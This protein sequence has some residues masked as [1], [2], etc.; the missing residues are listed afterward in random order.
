MHAHFKRARPAYHAFVSGI[1]RALRSPMRD[2]CWPLRWQPHQNGR[3]ARVRNVAENFK[4]RVGG[5][6]VSDTRDI[7]AR[8]L[9]PDLM[10]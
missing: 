1:I 9:M 3:H 10:L 7:L 6:R 5:V 4:R 8:M 2:E